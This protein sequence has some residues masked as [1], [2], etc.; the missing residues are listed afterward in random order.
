MMRILRNLALLIFVSLPIWLFGLWIAARLG[1]G[2]QGGSRW[3]EA[4]LFYFLVL[5]PQLLVGGIVHQLIIGV[6]SNRL[7]PGARRA[8]AVATV[9]IIPI[10]LLL[11]GGAPALLFAPVNILCLGTALLV[12]GVLL[13]M[14]SQSEASA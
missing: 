10:V 12:Y 9:I 14:S 7:P 8:F 4:S 11:F 6:A 2:P 1:E 5:A 13:Q 3:P